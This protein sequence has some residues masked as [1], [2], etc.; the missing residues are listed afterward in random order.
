[1]Q[2]G[3]EIP[4]KDD[5]VI[6]EDEEEVGEVEETD[7]LE[8][9]DF[10]IAIIA[11]TIHNNGTFAGYPTTYIK[12]ATDGEDANPEFNIFSLSAIL[13]EY[14]NQ[15]I[16]L[17]CSDFENNAQAFNILLEHALNIRIENNIKSYIFIEVDGTIDPESITI[18]ASPENI[19]F[20][21]EII[22]FVV[23]P[24]MPSAY[25]NI[26][27]VKFKKFLA[28]ENVQYVFEIDPFNP[29]DTGDFLKIMCFMPDTE[30]VTVAPRIVED[31]MIINIGAYSQAL[32]ELIQEAGFTNVRLMPKYNQLLVGCC[33][34]FV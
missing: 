19:E 10:N 4:V 12:F 1:M 27:D 8:D 11:N 26:T 18:P 29:E 7:N 24:K 6:P 14:V 17:A 28:M 22:Q 25:G 9:F 15:D 33:N 34:K 31:E 30:S 2:I 5:A 23:C 13:E 3:K 16:T 20:A 21:M 32:L